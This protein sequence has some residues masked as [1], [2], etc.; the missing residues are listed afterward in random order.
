MALRFAV[1][2]ELVGKPANRVWKLQIE[3]VLDEVDWA[4]SCATGEALVRILW[5]IDR[6]IADMMVSV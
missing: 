3:H 2:T 6:E 4:T 1:D 5:W